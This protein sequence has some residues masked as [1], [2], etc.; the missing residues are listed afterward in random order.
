MDTNNT[1]QLPAPLRPVALCLTLAA[2][3][4]A[5]L[6]TPGPTTD[7]ASDPSASVVRVFT[8]VDGEAVE[9]PNVPAAD[10]SPAGTF[11]G[12]F[13]EGDLLVLDHEALLPFVDATGDVQLA[14]EDGTPITMVRAGSVVD[15]LV[16]LEAE[17]GTPLALGTPRPPAFGDQLRKLSA[18]WEKASWLDEGSL[19]EPGVQLGRR[20]ASTEVILSEWLGIWAAPG[21]PVLDESGALAGVELVADVERAWLV[22][23]ATLDA[24]LEQARTSEPRSI[25]DYVAEVLQPTGNPGELITEDAMGGLVLDCARATCHGERVQFERKGWW[26]GI[27]YWTNPDDFVTFEV[28]LSE[29]ATFD[30]R[31]LSSCP[32]GTA[33]TEVSLG[34]DHSPASPGSNLTYRVPATDSFLDFRWTEL[35]ELALPAGRSTISLRPLTAPPLAVMDLDRFVLMPAASGR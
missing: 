2:L 14:L 7:V 22:P 23:R 18:P 35:G 5:S 8:L 19:L 32:A 15:G 16:V 31:A 34:L 27:G 10:G 4:C 1:A 24:L 11:Q 17:G 21:R 26:H 6:E 30:V 29:A 28:E 20:R 9:P 3:G 25:A 12:F 33:G 13:V